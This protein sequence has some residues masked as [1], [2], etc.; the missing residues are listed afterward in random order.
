LKYLKLAGPALYPVLDKIEEAGEPKPNPL[1]SVGFVA[2][3][4]DGNVKAQILVHS[5]CMA[6]YTLAEPGFGHCLGPLFQMAHE[7]VQ[8]SGVPR[9]L[10]H[11]D[12]K[13]MERMLKRVKARP[14]PVKMWQL[15]RG[16]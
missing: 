14:W 2:V 4:D 13:A 11:T 8:K 16:K 3:D 9:V 1:L 10:M 15:L 5:V 6:E 7:F 12:S